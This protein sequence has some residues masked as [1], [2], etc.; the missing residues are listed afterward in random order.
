MPVK[1]HTP[2][3]AFEVLRPRGRR[4]RFDVAV[5][6]GLTPLVGRERVILIEAPSSA[7][8]GGMLRV[9]HITL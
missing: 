4:M 6:R 7:Y 2:V 9:G 8:P 3:R 5:E 1:G